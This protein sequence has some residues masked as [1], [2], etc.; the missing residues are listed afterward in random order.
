[1]ILVLMVLCKIYNKKDWLMLE[2]VHLS[3]V[4]KK[5]VA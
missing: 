4:R 5:T 3:T 1:M 2:L